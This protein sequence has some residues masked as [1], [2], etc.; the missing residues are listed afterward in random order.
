MANI[1][2]FVDGQPR[3][4]EAGASNLAKTLATTFEPKVIKSFAEG[5]PIVKAAKQS[6]TELSSYLANYDKG[7]SINV[8]KIAPDANGRVFFNDTLTGFNFTSD[9]QTLSAALNQMLNN[10]KEKASYYVGSTS[11][12]HYFPEL[13]DEVYVDGLA[14]K[15]ILNIWLG[16]QTKVAT[17]YDVA[18]NLAIVGA[19][20][21]TFILFPPEQVDNLYI[22]PLD[23][24]PGGQPISMANFDEIDF[25]Q[26]PKLKTAFDSAIICELEAGDAL[27]IPSMWWHYVE[28]TENVNVLINYWWHDKPQTNGK[29][30][31]ALLYAIWAIRD[32]PEAERRAWQKQFNH[33]VF[34]STDE[35]HAHIEPNIKSI[36]SSPHDDLTGRKLRAELQNRLRK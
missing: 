16:N 29:P 10:D 4:L 24:A 32:L 11:I 12:K 14:E 1:Y 35:T 27:F 34:E 25:E 23:K 19:G 30:A 26:F 33:Y 18:N 28:S 9:A 8:C 21:R 5:W 31:D 7:H 36:L 13:V 17:H 6:N 22:G 3:Y 15:S 20:K 2:Q